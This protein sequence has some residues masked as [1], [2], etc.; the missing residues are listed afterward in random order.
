MLS[1]HIRNLQRRMSCFWTRVFP[2]P[3]GEAT[4]RGLTK[5][6]AILDSNASHSQKPFAVAIRVTV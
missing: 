3:A 5:Q 4:E 1:M 6:R 2:A